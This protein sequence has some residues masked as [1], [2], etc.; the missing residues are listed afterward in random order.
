MPDPKLPAG[1]WSSTADG[2]RSVAARDISGSVNTGD[3]VH[4]H[5][6]TKPLTP[7]ADVQASPGTNNLPGRPRL[8]VGHTHVLN[9]LN[10]PTETAEPGHVDV[11]CGLGG[12]GKT[13]LAARWAA[14]Q[15]ARHSVVWWIIADTPE[16]VEQ[17]LSNL[18]EVLQP[19][20][21][22]VV[23]REVLKM[24]A[25]QW[26]SS[27]ADWVVVLD[28]VRDPKHVRSLLAQAA[29]G[30]FLITTRRATG[31]HNTATHVVELEVLKRQEAVAL[32]TAI[33]T[34]PGTHAM[35]GC[36]DLCAELGDLPLAI[37]QVGAF[38]AEA[39]I[40]PK[41]Y[42]E[43]LASYPA[44]AYQ[45]TAEGGEAERTIARI[46]NVTMAKLSDEPLPGQLL[47]I[48][49][50]YA[51]D[52]IPRTLIEGI[53]DPAQ[54]LRALKRLN[55]YSMIK[56]TTSSIS[57]HRLVQAVSRTPAIN[58]DD[59]YQ[60]LE[61]IT[62]TRAQ[63]VDLLNHA[64]PPS[65]VHN[66]SQLARWMSLIAHID[67]LC[68]NTDMSSDTIDEAHLFGATGGYLA[69]QGSGKLALKYLSRAQSYFRSAR[70]GDYDHEVKIRMMLADAYRVAGDLI[71]AVELYSALLNDSLNDSRYASVIGGDG[72]LVL[73]ND[74]GLALQH[75]GDLEMAREL[76]EQI[77][78]QMVQR[79]GDVD[80]R[81]LTTSNNL[82]QV[83]DAMGLP[84][85][86]ITVFEQVLAGRQATLGNEHCETLITRSNLARARGLA[87][88]DWHQAVGRLEV[89]LNDFEL[90]FGANYVHRLTTRNE[91]AIALCHIGDFDR[92]IPMFEQAYRGYQVLSGPDHLAALDI[93][94]NLADAHL[95]KGNIAQA[96][97]L[98][99]EAFAR[100]MS[101]LEPDYANAIGAALKAAETHLS[102]GNP[103]RARELCEQAL[104]ITS[105]RFGDN[106][107][108]TQTVRKVLA[109]LTRL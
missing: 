107:A 80:Q 21:Q 86:A 39:V 78:P 29:D 12:I 4:V 43:L 99:E 65:H 66:P 18:A 81:S 24:R 31:W 106:H 72:L 40:T 68:E 108:S 84:D 37:E 75:A 96:A 74:F 9:Q 47:R 7:I 49:S 61:V 34:H 26:L 13:T 35:D 102:I 98:Y 94:M 11:I 93:C 58:E 105:A 83:Y 22:G 62:T 109:E 48:L 57:L 104:A 90:I 52:A 41:A 27:H 17:G 5:M 32:L 60:P 56:L 76:Y 20:L 2:V 28:G 23:S 53:A 44:Q 54:L 100:Y 70:P 77:V 79:F 101:S 82:A 55:A 6:P 67:A 92:S 89:I 8:F 97:E 50:W 16:R 46:W 25:I 64:L 63:A 33:A 91:L 1:S 14:D 85:R 59:P 10:I 15:I 38:I 42:L 30:R 19:E 71:R 95:A 36:E 69:S 3:A 88:G 103:A 87:T 45:W 73:M 51:P